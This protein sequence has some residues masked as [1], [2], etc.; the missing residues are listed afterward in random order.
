METD[1]E[2]DQEGLL[3]EQDPGHWKWMLF[4]PTGVLLKASVWFC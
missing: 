3:Q 4:M 2:T 1:L